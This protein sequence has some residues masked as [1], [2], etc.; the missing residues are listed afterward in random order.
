[1]KSIMWLGTLLVLFGILAL[2]VPVFTTSR[3][4][5]MVKIGILGIQGFEQ[6]THEVPPVLS[7]SLLIVGI[8]LLGVG[9]YRNR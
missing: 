8:I 7:A 9:F 1:M 2:A 6:A 5:N 4:K 3:P